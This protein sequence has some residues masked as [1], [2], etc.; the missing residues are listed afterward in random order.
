[1]AVRNLGKVKQTVEEA[2]GLDVSHVWEDLVFVEMGALMI[3]FDDTNPGHVWLHFHE[4]CNAEDRPS[5]L[6]LLTKAGKS[7]GL[8]FTTAGDFNMVPVE[9]KEEITVTFS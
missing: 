4:D 8:A 2:L 1:M 6:D 3:R 7:N 5:L 9:G